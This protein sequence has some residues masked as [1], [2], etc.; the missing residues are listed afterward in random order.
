MRHSL[1]EEEYLD[2]LSK[3]YSGSPKL[4]LKDVHGFLGKYFPL[5][6][7]GLFLCKDMNTEL[8]IR[9]KLDKDIRLDNTISEKVKNM[10]KKDNYPI[11]KSLK[12]FSFSKEMEDQYTNDIDELMIL[13]LQDGKEFLGFLFFYLSKEVSITTKTKKMLSFISIY[14]SLLFKNKYYY[15]NME[16]RLAELLTLQNVGD[17]VNSTLDFEKLL[18]ISLDAIVGLIGLRTCSITV[19]TDKLFN[20]IYARSQKSLVNT[21]DSS[22]E[23]EID[24][25]RGLYADL[26]QKRKPVSGILK[27]SKDILDLILFDSISEGDQVQYIIIPITRGDELFGSINIFDSTLVHV[28]NIDSHFLESFANQ[29]SIALQNANL[30]RKQ[31]EMANK[32]GLTNLYNHAYFQS[33]LDKL[34]EKKDMLPLS[35][36]FMDIDDFKQVNDQYGHLIGDKVLKELSAILL[37]HSR[38]GDLVA[39]Y[40]GEEFAVILPGTKASEAIEFAERLREIIANNLVLLDDNDAFKV[41]VSIGVSEYQDDWSKEDFVDTVDRLLYQAKNNGKNRVEFDL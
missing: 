37:K 3:L 9:P 6:V 17:F 2:F 26:S 36:V 19:F 15:E 35:L 39:R 32:D 20:D 23:V 30:Y 38:D 7:S 22:K 28:N 27:V 25:S 1:F 33:V 21:V 29:F 5:I 40:G 10:I 11:I 18:D 41:T 14:I 4:I 12:D 31:S 8:T 24:L 16:Q 34:I 13:P